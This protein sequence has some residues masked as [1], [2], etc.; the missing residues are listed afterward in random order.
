M[1][2]IIEKPTAEE[3]AKSYSAAYVRGAGQDSDIS[4]AHPRRLPLPC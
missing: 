1:T 4:S 2:D 3:V